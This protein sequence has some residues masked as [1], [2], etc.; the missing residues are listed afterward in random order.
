MSGRA[1]GLVAKYGPALSRK[2]VSGRDARTWKIPE[3]FFGG[4]Y[5]AVSCFV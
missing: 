4:D 5:S 1:L 2:A 3:E